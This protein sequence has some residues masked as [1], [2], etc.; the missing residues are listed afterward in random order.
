VKG[1]THI[2]ANVARIVLRISGAGIRSALQAGLKGVVHHSCIT[3]SDPRGA[4]CSDRSES[5]SE[6]VGA[7]LDRLR[8]GD[9]QVA[10][11]V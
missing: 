6:I 5:G 1:A 8:D 9:E 11:P 2:D 4:A 10:V 7:S 3:D